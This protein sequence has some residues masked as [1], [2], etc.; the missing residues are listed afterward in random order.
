MDEKCCTEQEEACMR[1][2]KYHH[3][4]SRSEMLDSI[5]HLF[6]DG[7][8]TAN[9]SDFKYNN[10]LGKDMCDNGTYFCPL[11]FH[12]IP[13]NHTCNPDRVYEKK[14]DVFDQDCD[15]NDTFCSLYMHCIP[16]DQ[17][18]SYKALFDW[19]NAGNKSVDPFSRPCP[20]N[21]TFCPLTFSC[22]DGCESR[23]IMG[24]QSCNATEGG[25]CPK[26]LENLGAEN[27]TNVTDATGS[28]KY[29]NL[30]VMCFLV[31]DV[32]YSVKVYAE[33]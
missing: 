28:G 27:F 22:R 12:C 10:L 11:V 31:C 2:V 30:K 32:M 33:N 18:C 20:E 15:G 23:D 26:T 14:I 5:C 25:I 21:Q 6:D 24:N 29:N 8:F 17:D 9:Y 19:Y 3:F 7:N 4:F 13:L 1:V 16:S